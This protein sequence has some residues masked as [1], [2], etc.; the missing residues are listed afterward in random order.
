MGSNWWD[1]HKSQC[2]RTHRRHMLCNMEVPRIPWTSPNIDH[3]E[4]KS[5]LVVEI[6]FMTRKVLTLLLAL[7][8]LGATPVHALT[9]AGAKCTKVGAT[10]TS[11]GKKY[12]CIK[13]GKNLVWNKGVTV[14]KA[15]VVKKAVC[16]SKSSQDIDPGI[17]Q[18]RANN[19]LTMSEADA[20][21]CAMELDWQFRVG[22]RDGEMFAG[23]F[24]YRTDR[25]TVTVMKGFV[26]KVYLG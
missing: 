3:D 17:T 16:P 25:V 23:T 21:M 2:E 15:V 5:L 20:E 18:T 22:Q 9:K 24:D 19:L 1:L 6:T 10:A 8:L 7:T 12:T 14:K 11:A 13:S 26:T 4:C